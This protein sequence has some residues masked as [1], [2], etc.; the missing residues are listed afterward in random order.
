MIQNIFSE[1]LIQA[2]GWTMIHS[3][4]QGF[5]VAI[6][7]GL[8][9]I[10]LQ[11][12]ANRTG[13]KSAKIRYEIAWFALFLV[14]V[15]SLST[16]IYLYDSVSGGEVLGTT[17]TTITEAGITVENAEI[18][19][20][21]FQK[22]IHYF[23]EHLS[24]IVTLWLMGMLFFFL[25]LLGGIAYVERLKYQKQNK[26]PNEWQQIF[27][28]LVARF[29]MKKTVRLAESSLAKVPMVIGYFKPIILFPV[30]AVNQLSTQEVEA[31]LAHELAHIYRND[32]LLNI[33]QSIIEI[34]F[35]YHPA[36]WWISANIRTERENC[37]DDIAV[38]LCGNSLTYVKALVNLEEMHSAPSLAMSFSSGSK[39]QLLNRVKRILNQPQN[40]FNIMEK[41]TATCFLLG[42]LLLFSVSATEPVDNETTNEQESITIDLQNETE[43]EN[44]WTNDTIPTPPAPTMKGEGRFRFSNDNEK[45]EVEYENDEIVSLK[46]NGETIPENEY[47]DYEE[48]VEELMESVPAPPVPPVRPRIGGDF[49]AP[50]APPVPPHLGFSPSENKTITEFENKN[51]KIVITQDED[52]NTVIISDSYEEGENT[53]VVIGDGELSLNGRVIQLDELPLV[54]GDEDL[55]INF[56][57]IKFITDGG[58]Q[59]RSFDSEELWIPSLAEIP[60]FLENFDLDEITKAE[61]PNIRA[62]T[63]PY[64]QEIEAQSTMDQLRKDMEVERQI[65]REEIKMNE[66]IIKKLEKKAKEKS[67]ESRALVEELARAQREEMAEIQQQQAER[68]AELREELRERR[69]EMREEQKA[70]MDEMREQQREMRE[71]RTKEINKWVG[72]FETQLKKDGHIANDGSYRFSLTENRLKINRKKQSE[73]ERERYQELYEST[74]GKDLGNKFSIKISTDGKNNKKTSVSISSLDESH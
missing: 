25:R 17:I 69:L 67:G 16:F 36:V 57:D 70:R 60:A 28:K 27:E 18:V 63:I 53:H 50:P 21:F 19:Q 33:I 72:I 64:N 38:Q 65:M 56:P 12:P 66:R 55:K 15:L 20:T 43:D 54:F 52:G 23:N 8:A 9:M 7:M 2:L 11:K 62:D 40:K 46:I 44:T 22:T 29:P 13:W 30:G 37:C 39:N 73:A 45:V 14:F 47:A 68:R 41:F 24:L 59:I 10:V 31:V 51:K 71:T 4:W 34:I 35:Y 61:Y 26:L 1:D 49:V 42:V 32:Y 48:H 3:L 58:I 74:M 6:L 5:A